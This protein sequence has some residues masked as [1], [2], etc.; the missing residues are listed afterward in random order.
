M[1]TVTIEKTAIRT[2]LIF[3]EFHVTEYTDGTCRYEDYP[4]YF[5]GVITAL[6]WGRAYDNAQKELAQTQK[7]IND[8]LAQVEAI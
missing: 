2:R 3:G 4:Y 1:N 5:D 7:H 8:L 6:S